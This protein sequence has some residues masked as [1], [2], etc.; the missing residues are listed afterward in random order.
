MWNDAR[1]CTFLLYGILQPIT[2]IQRSPDP[3][4]KL[5]LQSENEIVIYRNM[6]KVVMDDVGW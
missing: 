1:K 2:A 3:Q 4:T 6:T 5:H